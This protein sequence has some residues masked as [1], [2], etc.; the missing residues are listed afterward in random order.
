MYAV[1]DR[2]LHAVLNCVIMLFYF[3]FRYST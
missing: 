1:I 2:A 3:Y